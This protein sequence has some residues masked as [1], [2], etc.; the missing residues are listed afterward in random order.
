MARATHT[1]SLPHV[2]LGSHDMNLF[3]TP[4]HA[5]TALEHIHGLRVDM[6]SGLQQVVLA[7]LRERAARQRAVCTPQAA[8]RFSWCHATPSRARLS[9]YYSHDVKSVGDVHKKPWWLGSGRGVAQ[10]L[11]RV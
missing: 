3:P 10:F 5:H 2:V 6:C 4:Q 1:W 7:A 8:G 9:R 11:W